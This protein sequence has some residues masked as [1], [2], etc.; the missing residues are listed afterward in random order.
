MTTYI[1]KLKTCT[2]HLCA[3]GN[4]LYDDFVLAA[5]KVH[6]APDSDRLRTDCCEAAEAYFIHRRG[7]PG[8]IQACPH[9]RVETHL[10][11]TG[12]LNTSPAVKG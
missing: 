8:H 7:L 1:H 9:C 10:Q 3:E 5:A 4:R 11:P 6:Y 2:L 12:T